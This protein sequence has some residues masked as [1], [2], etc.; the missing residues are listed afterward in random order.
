MA[1]D[2]V[3]G[4]AEDRRRADLKDRLYF[5]EVGGAARDRIERVKREAKEFAFRLGGGDVGQNL[6]KISGKSEPFETCADIEET[7]DEGRLF[8]PIIVP[9]PIEDV[10]AVAELRRR[11]HLSA[12]HGAG[13]FGNGG[14][15][16]LLFGKERNQA[17]CLFDVRSA[18][19]K[20]SDFCR[21]TEPS[22][23]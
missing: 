11:R 9:F 2:N 3:G 12:F 20:P 1:G 5:I 4:K 23:L 19:H 6:A 16:A 10:F 15:D 17:V 13:T 8:D 18:D 14:D 7:L 21:H 22:S